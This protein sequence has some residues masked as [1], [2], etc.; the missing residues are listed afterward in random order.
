M[1][2]HSCGKAKK[3]LSINMLYLKSPRDLPASSSHGFLAEEEGFR[4]VRCLRR[5]K[6]TIPRKRESRIFSRPPLRGDL[7][8]V[9]VPVHG[10]LQARTGLRTSEPV[11]GR[12]K[13]AAERIAQRHHLLG[14]LPKDRQAGA[15]GGPGPHPCGPPRRG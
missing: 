5:R 8:P 13:V 4:R 15:G 11:L 12:A 9:A 6:G 2:I 7:F 14:R 3:D 1:V 10:R